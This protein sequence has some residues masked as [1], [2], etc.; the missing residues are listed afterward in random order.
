MPLAKVWGRP[1]SFEIGNLYRQDLPPPEKPWSGIPEFSFVGGN[2]DEANV[3]VAGLTEAAARVLQREGRRLAIYNLGGSP[4]GHEDLRNFVSDKLGIRAATTVEPDQVLITSGSLQALDLVNDLLLSPGDNVIVEE[5]T[6]G[7]MLSRLH[8]LG[9]VVHGVRLD[10][11]GVCPEHL[12]EVL[13]RCVSEGRPAKYLYTIPT[14]QNPTGSCM[15]LERRLKI[16]EVMDEYETAIF[17]D[18]CYADLL[19]G[20]ARPPTLWELDQTD[21]RVIYCGSFSKSIAP[22]LRVGYLIADSSIL[23]QILALK[24]DAGSGALEQMIVAEYAASHFN[25][26]AEQLTSVLHRKAEVMAEAVETHFGNSVEFT[27][28]KGGI[29]MWLVFAEDIDTAEF[30]AAATRNGIEFNAGA[31]WSAN[32]DWGAN[33][34]R[35]CFGNPTED[36]IREGVRRL[37]EI[38]N[39]P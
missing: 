31:G 15:P 29:F 12:R 2:N 9:V 32:S 37:S 10:S 14:V 25:D 11:N 5:A 21:T 26:H 33:K 8:R 20:C 36:V 18:D 39:L 6:Y 23:Q 17:E 13:D 4:L 34:M 7:G 38:M 28:P 24:V 27:M 19:W 1:L 22:A 30:S 35:L 16:L 3:P